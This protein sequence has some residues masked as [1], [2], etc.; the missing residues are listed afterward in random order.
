MRDSMRFALAVALGVL[1]GVAGAKF[2]Q[3]GAW[4][5]IP[6]GIGGLAIA[7]AP[8]RR[9]AAVTGGVYGFVLSFT[10][11]VAAYTGAA[12]LV[13]RLLP[14]ALLGLFGALCGAALGAVGSFVRAR[15]VPAGPP[16]GTT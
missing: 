13:S 6:W 16:A 4:T 7:S 3:L 1:L 12:P 8:M 5:L 9:A 15:I 14:F 11:M 2:Q 10:F